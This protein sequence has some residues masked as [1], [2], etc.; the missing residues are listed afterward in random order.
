MKG[1]GFC[2]LCNFL[3]CPELLFDV[4]Q[5]KRGGSFPISREPTCNIR[6]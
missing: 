5:Q 6:Y 4:V 3:V 1:S 2:V